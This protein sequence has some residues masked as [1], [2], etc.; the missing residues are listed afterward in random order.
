M[1]TMTLALV[2]LLVALSTMGFNCINDSFDVAVNM[3]LTLTLPVIAGPAGPYSGSATIHLKDLVDQSY[4]DKLKNA[5]LYDIRISTSGQYAGT[6]SGTVK[7]DNSTLLTYSGAWN[8]FNSPVSLFGGSTLVQKNPAG[9]AAVIAL[10]NGFLTNQDETTVL[11]GNG[12]IG[13]ATVPNGLSITIQI[14]AQVDSEVQS[15]G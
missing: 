10:L 2:A 13:T 11:S 12:T 8:D 4:R 7:I 9:V 15:G 3:P 6:V 1:K 14:L 5:R